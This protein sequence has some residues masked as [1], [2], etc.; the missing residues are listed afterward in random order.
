MDGRLHVLRFNS[1]ALDTIILDFFEDRSFIV[2]GT[3]DERCVLAINHQVIRFASA[4]IIGV[5]PGVTSL[6]EADRCP[7]GVD[8][9]I[10]RYAAH[11][12]PNTLR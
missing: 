4:R 5:Y 10:Q 6:R 7:I 12:G 11:L 3:E 1:F 2:V 9:I 8:E